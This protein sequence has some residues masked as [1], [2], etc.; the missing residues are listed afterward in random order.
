MNK[1]W[2]I[3]KKKISCLILTFFLL[4]VLTPTTYAEDDSADGLLTLD[5]AV[6]MALKKS[7]KLKEIDYDIERG[8]EVRESAASKVNFIPTGSDPD[9]MAA[10]AFTTLVATDMGLQMTKKGKDLEIDKIT[11]N[12]F[13]KYTEVITAN[14]DFELAKLQQDKAKRDWQVALLSYDTGL[15]SWSQLKLAEAGNKTANTSYELAQ[16]KADEAYQDLN[17]LIG[18]KPGDRPILTADIEYTPLEVDDLDFA[19][20]RIMADNP[21]IW[22]AE[23]QA[24]LEKLKLDLYSWADPY[25]EPYSA[26]KIDVDK[27]ELSAVDAKRQM[28][29]G[30]NTLYLQ[31]MQLEDNY[32]IAEQGL[33]VAETEFQV[34][35]LQYELGM[36]SKQDYL[37]AEVAL[38]KVQNDFSKILYQHE[39]LKQTF[40]KPWAYDPMSIDASRG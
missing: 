40:Y 19:I 34:K 21:A 9:P 4:L 28:R 32:K 25:R 6:E 38:A 10:T 13:K 39:S 35:K 11:F 2:L 15:I 20:A 29:E 27:A 5:K 3:M 30:L 16:K 37:A 14:H 31:I 8:E 18:L 23:E 17:N 22:L 26:K 7:N 36:L 12:V 33:K 24:N 1:G